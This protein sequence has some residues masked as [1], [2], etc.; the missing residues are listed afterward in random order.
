LEGKEIIMFEKSIENFEIEKV[1]RGTPLAEELLH[2][3]EECSWVEVK[4]HMANLVRNW[5]FSDWETMFVAK[6]DGKIIGMASVMKEDYY[7]LPELYPWVSCVFVEEKYRGLKISGKL[8]DFTN[9]Y[10]K[11]QGFE[12]S[13][14]PTPKENIGL[15]EHYG[16]SFDKEIVNYDGGVD[17]LYSKEIM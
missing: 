13:Y 5:E 11:D 12:K 6:A 2:F 8:I 10:L 1:D 14:I 17:L 9:E 16:Y 7:P 15:Y 3:I 4:E